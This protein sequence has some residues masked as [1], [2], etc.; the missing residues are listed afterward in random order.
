MVVLGTSTGPAGAG[1]HSY[2]YIGQLGRGA[3]S[4]LSSYCDYLQQCDFLDHCG[5]SIEHCDE[6]CDAIIKHSDNLYL[7]GYIE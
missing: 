2:L 6:Q 3:Q 4:R 5:W 7:C 1:Q